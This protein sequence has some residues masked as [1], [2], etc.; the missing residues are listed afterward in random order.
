MSSGRGRE[1]DNGFRCINC[2]SFVTKDEYIGTKHRNHCPFCLYSMHVDLNSPGDRKSICKSKME[3]I[4]LTVK[5]EGEDKYGEERVGELMLVHRCCNEECQKISINRIA[6]D[7][8]AQS[9]LKVYTDSLKLD[10]TEKKEFICKH[11]IAV[12]DQKDEDVVKTQ[13]FGNNN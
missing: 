7:D 3:P 6:G 8:D 13:L 2:K 12:L 11:G 5:K 9:I 1:K 4:A 10:E